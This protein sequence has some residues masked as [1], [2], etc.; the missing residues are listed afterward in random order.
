MTRG[1]PPQLALDEAFHIA[2]TRGVV[3]RILQESGS[4]GD[5]MILSAM[6]WSLVR[7]KRTLRL[8]CP[9]KEIEVQ[10]AAS[11]RSLRSVPVSAGNQRELWVWS[12]YRTWRFFRVEES[13]L[14]E[15]VM[16]VPHNVPDK[17]PGVDEKTPAVMEKG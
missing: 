12:R 11:V 14:V 4:A 16:M 1:R 9:L 10:F 13:G 8:H 15:Q 3:Y 5:L 2:R 6:Q 7:V 17:E